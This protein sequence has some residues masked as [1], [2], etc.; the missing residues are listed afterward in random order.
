MR[1]RF[2]LIMLMYCKHKTAQGNLQDDSEQIICFRPKQNDPGVKTPRLVC[3]ISGNALETKLDILY[4]QKNTWFGLGATKHKQVY[5]DTWLC[6][7]KN[8]VMRKK[9]NSWKLQ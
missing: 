2:D 6:F 1:G 5:K 7:R 4:V 3:H 9:T 8:H